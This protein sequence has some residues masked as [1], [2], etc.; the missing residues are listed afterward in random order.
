MSAELVALVQAASQA[1][2][3]REEAAAKLAAAQA[4]MDDRQTEYD[5]AAAVESTAMTQLI[6]AVSA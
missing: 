6:A 2:V 1:S 3:K 5:A 4:V